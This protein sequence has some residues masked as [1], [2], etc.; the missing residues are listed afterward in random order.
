LSLLFVM[1]ATAHIA[2]GSN[3]GDRREHLEQAIQALQDHPK[4]SVTQISSFIETD[5]VGGPPGQSRYLNAAAELE[6]SLSPRELLKVFLDAEQKLGRVRRER[7]GPRTIDIDLLLYDNF[8]CHEKDL[9][10]PHPRMTERL[11][12][13]EPLAEIASNVVHPVTGQTI[14]ELLYRARKRGPDKPMPAESEPA[15]SNLD[16]ERRVGRVF[17]AHQVINTAQELR[18]LRALVTGSTSGIGQ[19][20]AQELAASGADLMVH[21]RQEDKAREVAE[22]IREAGV[23]SHIFFAELN[24][25]AELEELVSSAW[26]LWD[27]IDIWINNAGADILTGEAAKWS[28]DRKL[29]ELWTVDVKATVFLSRA[30]GER[31]KVQGRGAILNMGWDQAETGMESDSGQLFG[32]IKAAVM[33]FTRSLALTL[34]PEVRVNCLAPGWIR[35]AWGEKASAA[36]QERATRETPLGRWGLPSDVAAAA[37]WLV[38]PK[39]AFL[40]GQTIR[41]NGGAVR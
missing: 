31:M 40:T 18:G 7:D 36:W 35:T 5:P 12:V 1:T 13:L 20:I 28:F 19:A 22:Q 23:K 15:V 30:I 2:L 24:N 9:V 33:A 8:A 38:S 17:E 14:G 16:A 26:A 41:V 6:T 37:R 29:E 25:R 3:L 21:G 34:A 32:T 39:A 10:V 11:F 4:I 27:G